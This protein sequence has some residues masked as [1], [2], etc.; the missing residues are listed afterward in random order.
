MNLVKAHINKNHLITLLPLFL[1]FLFHISFLSCDEI[2]P[3]AP[4]PVSDEYILTREP[5]L[6]AVNLLLNLI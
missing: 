4:F 2:L 3:D 1:S 6:L 5:V